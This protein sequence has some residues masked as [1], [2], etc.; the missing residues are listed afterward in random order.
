MSSDLKPVYEKLDE[1]TFE[2]R[3][4]NN[5]IRTHITLFSI[6]QGV[7]FA[8]FMFN[9]FDYLRSPNFHNEWLEFAPFPFISF[10]AIIIISCEYM[11]FI[12]LFSWPTRIR[13]HLTPFLIGFFEACPMFFFSNPHMWWFCM[14]LLGIGGAVASL[15]IMLDARRV[16]FTDN[17]S[18][19]KT[20]IIQLWWNISFCT[21]VFIVSFF[22][23]IYFQVLDDA[24]KYLLL[25]MIFILE[26]VMLWRGDIYMKK[27]HEAF[28]FKR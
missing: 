21:A 25:A 13:D 8:L 9:V 7:A 11:W 15:N 1:D 26:I 3:I 17:T 22:A 16:K 14:I 19:Y 12:G 27:L 4:K 2:N 23:W 18:A 5:F 20:I 10:T 24:V 28:G 6:I